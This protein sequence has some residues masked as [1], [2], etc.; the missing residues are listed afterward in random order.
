MEAYLYAFG[1]SITV[2]AIVF[3]EQ[4]FYFGAYRCGSQLRVVLSAAV[5]RK[6]S[7]IFPCWRGDDENK[8][9]SSSQL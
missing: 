7:Q 9:N 6:V 3:T 2:F 1:L 8:I 4:P 5:Y